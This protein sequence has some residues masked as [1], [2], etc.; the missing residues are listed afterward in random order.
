M[1]NCALNDPKEYANIRA[2]LSLICYQDACQSLRLIV[3]PSLGW[4]CS[5]LWSLPLP[6]MGKWN[7]WGKLELQLFRSEH[8]HKN[9]KKLF[10]QREVGRKIRS[11]WV[12]LGWSAHTPYTWRRRLGLQ[13]LIQNI[14]NW[15]FIICIGTTATTVGTHAVAAKQKSHHE[16]SLAR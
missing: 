3:L 4:V 16:P 14:L 12:W 15:D 10:F 9:N 8:L 5:V 6:S 2:I 11:Q 7:Y 1:I 13:E